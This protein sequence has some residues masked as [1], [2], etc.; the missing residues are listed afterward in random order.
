LQASVGIGFGNASGTKVTAEQL[1]KSTSFRA[2]GGV[3]TQASN[4]QQWPN[5]VNNPNNW[6]VIG[7]SNLAPI[8]DWL[9]P[10][11]RARVERLLPEMRRAA[12]QVPQGISA[13]NPFSQSRQRRIHLRNAI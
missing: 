2:K 5:T 3:A 6:G 9:E 8:T 10:A 1:N 11:L 4:P 13:Q 7:V 12:L